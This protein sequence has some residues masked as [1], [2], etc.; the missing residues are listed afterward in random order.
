MPKYSL[1]T[2][3]HRFQISD[4]ADGCKRE[5]VLSKFLF[6][7]E[8]RVFSV[9]LSIEYSL[10]K[11]IVTDQET[12]DFYYAQAEYE[13]FENR[14][15]LGRK[16][17]TFIGDEQIFVYFNPENINDVRTGEIL[18]PDR[19]PVTEDIV[20]VSQY[21]FIYLLFSTGCIPLQLIESLINNWTEWANLKD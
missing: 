5:V 17:D 20:Y 18:N 9:A 13:I 1:P 2:D 8:A 10:P 7:T 11:K 6:D 3:S 16:T 12:G 14:I 15:I 4:D 21:E 19:N